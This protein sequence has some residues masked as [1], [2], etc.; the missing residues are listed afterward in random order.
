MAAGMSRALLRPEARGGRA[1]DT[2]RNTPG[3]NAGD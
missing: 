1:G 2:Q 3:N